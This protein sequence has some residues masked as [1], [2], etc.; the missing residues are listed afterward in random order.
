MPQCDRFE[1][2]S[3]HL[4]PETSA[5]CTVPCVGQKN[6]PGKQRRW[7]VSGCNN[8]CEGPAK[9]EFLAR[10]RGPIENHHGGCPRLGAL[11]IQLSMGWGNVGRSNSAVKFYPRPTVRGGGNIRPQSLI[12]PTLLL[13]EWGP[14][15]TRITQVDCTHSQPSQNVE[16]CRTHTF[17]KAQALCHICGLALTPSVAYP[18]LDPHLELSPWNPPSPLALPSRPRSHF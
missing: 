2:V 16:G 14:H 9:H 4:T 12:C 15:H 3:Q 13:G 1:C 8:K 10:G 11:L 7:I 6:L 17:L 18:Q 5:G